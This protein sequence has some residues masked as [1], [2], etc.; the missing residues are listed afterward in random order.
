MCTSRGWQPPADLTP[1][2][3]PCLCM[4]ELQIRRS[5]HASYSQTAFS[6]GSRFHA[7]ER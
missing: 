7:S 1:S 6:L 5:L 3:T 2:S 4:P